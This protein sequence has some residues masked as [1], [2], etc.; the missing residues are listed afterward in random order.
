VHIP[1]PGQDVGG[2]WLGR[3]SLGLVVTVSV[4][5]KNGSVGVVTQSIVHLSMTLYVLDQVSWHMD[6]C[7]MACSLALFPLRPM[8]TTE[9]CTRRAVSFNHNLIVVKRS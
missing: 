1:D 4:T 9:V 5:Y 3:C 6:R 8:S 7:T 2:A